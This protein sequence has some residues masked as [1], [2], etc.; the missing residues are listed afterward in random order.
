MAKDSPLH[1]KI[2]DELKKIEDE[3]KGIGLDK[4]RV[5]VRLDMACDS[6][7]PKRQ[8]SL[9]IDK[10]VKARENELCKVDAV[11]ITESSKKNIRIIIEVEES[12]FNPTKI[13]GKFFTSA[14]AK[15]YIDHDGN[16]IE[17]D[18][19]IM[20]IQIIDKHKLFKNV[21]YVEDKEKEDR[22]KKK[23]QLENIGKE[24]KNVLKF[25][26][27]EKYELI[28]IDSNK[29]D[30]VELRYIIKKYLHIA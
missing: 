22:S 9:F 14:L 1:K 25:G 21:K 6:G 17:I 23:E 19:S 7:K 24:I 3:L 29:L 27:I 2:G 10:E 8:I 5:S 26:C 11:L 13:C 15:S 28:F 12:G 30:F 4:V 16:R 18:Q 20:F